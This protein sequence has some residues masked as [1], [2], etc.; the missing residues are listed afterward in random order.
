MTPIK[1]H[2]MQKKPPPTADAAELRRR[3]E[4]RLREQ[5]PEAGP[6][7]TEAD[8]QRLVHELQVHQIELEMQNDE[9][10]QA[11]NEI[12]VG[13]EKYSDLYEFAPVGYVT[14]DREGTIQEANL[15]A[16]SLLGVERS[17]LLESAFRDVRGR[18]QPGRLQH[19]SPAGLRGQGQGVLRGDA[20]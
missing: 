3:A 4:E 19:L 2:V 12:E 13:L 8:L 17:R 14:L 5:H 16:T 10:Q 9:L 6:D 11:R 15:T 1:N 18:T 7:R 20:P